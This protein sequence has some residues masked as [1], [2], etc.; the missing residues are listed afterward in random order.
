MLQNAYLT[1]AHLIISVQSQFILRQY[2]YIFQYI[3]VHKYIGTYAHG[4]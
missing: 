4:S 3:L 1:S 2:A